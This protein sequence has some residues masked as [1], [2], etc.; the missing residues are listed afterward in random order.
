MFVFIP[1][2][3]TLYILLHSKPHNAIVSKQAQEINK[4]KK[5]LK[6]SHET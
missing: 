4:W 3:I 6:W 2:Y 5:S 1:I